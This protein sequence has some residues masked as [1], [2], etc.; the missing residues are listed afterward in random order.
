MGARQRSGKFAVFFCSFS[1]FAFSSGKGRAAAHHALAASAAVAGIRALRSR[2]LPVRGLAGALPDQ[3]AVGGQ[4]ASGSASM[5]SRPNGDVRAIR[6]DPSTRPKLAN[7][8]GVTEFVRP[9]R[10]LGLLA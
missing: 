9:P 5:S 10:R 7:F 6:P 3:R 2:D 4:G 8:A 1:F